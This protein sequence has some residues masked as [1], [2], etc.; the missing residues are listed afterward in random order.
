MNFEQIINED[1]DKKSVIPIYYQIAKL[2][3]RKIYSGELKPGEKLPPENKI[4]DMFNI[5]RMTVRKALAELIDANM[6]YSEKGK[7]TFVAKPKLDN[8]AFEL[9][10]FKEEL[11]NRGLNPKT[12]LLNVKII[13]AD[14]D[15]ALKL[16]INKGRK[17]LDFSSI[18]SANN[19]P[20]IYESKFIV[21]SKHKPI[22]ENEIQDP[23]LSNIAMAHGDSFP[24]MSKK[25]L[26]VSKAN[27]KHAELL[28][29]KKDAPVFVIEQFL[30]DSADNAIGWG[31][32][33]CRGDKFKF[34]SYSGWS[35]D[36]KNLLGE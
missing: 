16:N 18:I 30:Y 23:S 4:A 26:N 15:L 27:N 13:R 8:T 34:T 32:S 28:N 1:I 31:K 7:G 20:L 11:K 17:C 14:K 29:I 21:Y 10:N 9:K 6:V 19:E 22:L 2:F 5:S 33:I 12:K 36:N 3:E 24:I 35:K 25:I